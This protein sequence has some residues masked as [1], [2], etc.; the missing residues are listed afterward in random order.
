MSMALGY[1]FEDPS[2]LTQ[3]SFIVG[4]GLSHKGGV[5]TMKLK[6]TWSFNV[7]VMPDYLE[8]CYRSCI[9]S[10]EDIDTSSRH[11]EWSDRSL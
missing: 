2:K 1:A 7:I 3:G 9:P 4:V 5:T 8:Y 11:G 6:P 10:K